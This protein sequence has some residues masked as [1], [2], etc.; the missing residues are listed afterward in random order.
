[1][2]EV[3]VEEQP[4]NRSAL[5][6]AVEKKKKKKKTFIKPTEGKFASL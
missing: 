1:M 3:P 5:R 4:I 2:S 6:L